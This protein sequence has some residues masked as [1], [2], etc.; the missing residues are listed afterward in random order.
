M[1]GIY[2]LV[3]HEVKDYDAWKKVFDEFEPVRIKHG[4]GSYHIFSLDGDPND[5]YILFEWD[6][7]EKSKKFGDLK[8]LHEAMEK[9]GV[10]GKPDMYYL[11]E[12]AKGA[13]Q[14]VH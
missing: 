3:H 1:N 9:A 6:S 2:M 8:E 14:L 7:K 4:G 11:D 10:V 13:L 5:V 12:R